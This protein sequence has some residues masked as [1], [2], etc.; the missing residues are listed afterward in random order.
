MPWPDVA[1]LC[2]CAPTL[3]ARR[4][5]PALLGA[6]L[7]APGLALGA[8]CY[9]D[10][11]A[12]GANDGTT[13][14]N[15][16]TD[17]QGALNN[18]ATCTEV[19]VAAGTY[20][21][22]GG[23][24][25]TISFNVRPG[26]KVYGGFAGGETSLGARDPAVNLTT[27]SG[28]IGTSADASDNSYHVMLMDGTTGTPITAT[29]VLDGFTV[30]A[31]NANAAYPYSYGGGLYCDGQGTGNACSPTLANL[32]FSANEASFGGAMVNRGYAGGT[33]SPSLSNVAF[34]GNNAGGIGGAMFNIAEGGGTSSPILT[35]VSFSDNSAGN[36]GGAMYNGSSG[37]GSTSSPVLTSVTF[38]NDR[39]TNSGG[40]LM[41]AAEDGGTSSPVLTN[42]TFSGNFAS[43]GGAMDDIVFGVGDEVSPALTN[44]TFT[45]NDAGTGGAMSNSGNEGGVIRPVLTNVT[46][47]GNS[48]GDGNAVY[49]DGEDGA[50]ID[51]V[52]TNVILWRDSAL[53]VVPEIL[54]FGTSASVTID[55]GVYQ[56]GCPVDPSFTCTNIVT[57]D[58]RLGPLQNNGGVTQ[59]LLPGTGSSAIDAGTASG[60]PATDQRGVP[61]PQI[62]GFDIGA[63][64]VRPGEVASAAP[65]PATGRWSL[66]MLA[67]LL[68]LATRRQRTRPRR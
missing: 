64:E 30:T 25:R 45:G 10:A 38:S 34:S 11:S 60:A 62:A 32:V 24:D 27:L 46:F 8:T 37:D 51:T 1:D 42:V 28:D 57:A 4:F 55:H 50:V 12:A 68:V 17:L 40:A 18:F 29:T 41:N 49:N 56:G 13:W 52:L 47:S 22:T 61:R 35:N 9:V 67:L 39:A 43:S 65:V 14:T 15:A 21:P 33:S 26:I 66:A 53:P 6:A 59:T 19:W 54:N 63:V 5:F 2:T 44:V 3:T 48:A 23:T 7:L 31:G 16:Y 36:F 20:K 58:P